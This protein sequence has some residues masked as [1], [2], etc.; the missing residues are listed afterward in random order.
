MSSLESLEEQDA[1]Q[2]RIDALQERLM[3]ASYLIAQSTRHLDTI[4]GTD[5]LRIEEEYAFKT[6]KPY[7]QRRKFS[8]KD[9]KRETARAA[10]LIR[11]AW[12]LLDPPLSAFTKGRQDANN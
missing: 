12:D 9:A 2:L 7:W 1:L 4:T 11:Q 3:Q 8:V 10:L 6:G 5:T